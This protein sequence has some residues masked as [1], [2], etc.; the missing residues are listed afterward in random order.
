MY[1]KYILGHIEEIFKDA[2]PFD[3]RPKRFNY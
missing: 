2:K 3:Q 1:P